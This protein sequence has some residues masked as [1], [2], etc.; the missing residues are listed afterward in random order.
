LSMRL[1]RTRHGLCALKARVKVRG[2][3]AMDVRTAAGR[4]LV[5]WRRETAEDLGDVGFGRD[6]I[7][8][9]NPYAIAHRR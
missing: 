9:F 5:T 1:R 3:T 4:A 7:G 2:L 6:V 8:R